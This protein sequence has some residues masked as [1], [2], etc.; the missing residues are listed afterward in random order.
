LLLALGLQGVVVQL[1]R[2]TSGPAPTLRLPA[3]LTA[4]EP[5]A[6]APLTTWEPA[7][8]NAVVNATRSYGRGHQAVGLWVAYYRDQSTARKMVTSSNGLVE[9]EPETQAQLHAGWAQTDSGTVEVAAAPGAA[10]RWVLKT[11]DL[12]GSS[13]PGSP[14]R[15]RLRV[16]HLYWIGG[17]FTPYTI[18]DGRARL[19][20]AIHRLL[21]RGDD[22]A[23]VFFY[24]PLAESDGG[25]ADARLA[26]A[27]REAL[28]TVEAMLRQAAH[29]P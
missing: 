10:G 27:V 29:H 13:H 18:S 9:I 24:T 11:A 22:A 15:Q 26:Q 21:G 4:G 8:A 1:N 25:A 23:V 12:R 20:P 7:Y 2:P 16:W 5:A 14:A 3:Q 28:P 19:E 6:E 17:P